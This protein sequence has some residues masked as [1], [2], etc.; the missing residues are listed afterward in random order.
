MAR[1]ISYISEDLSFDDAELLD[2][3]FTVPKS[4][5]PIDISSVIAHYNNIYSPDF[6]AN[7]REFADKKF[8]WDIALERVFDRI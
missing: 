7:M 8:N 3:V 6:S 4:D 5:D 2:Y 1:G